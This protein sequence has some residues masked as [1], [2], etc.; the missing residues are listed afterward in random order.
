MNT[1]RV[2]RPR[3]GLPRRQTGAVLVLY[4]VGMLA[5]LL[6][7]G[8]A[9]DGAHAMLNKSRLQNTVDAAA[10]SSAKVLDQTANMAQA[11]TAAL[12]MFA[13]NAND[14]G[15]RELGIAYAG[16]GGDINVTVEFSSTV[17]PFQSGTL[18]ANYVRVTATNFTMPAWLIQLMGID[19]KIVAA[20]A[21]AGPSPSIGQ[22]CDL[23]PLIVCG[24]PASPPDPN[25]PNASI[26]GYERGAVHVL[27]GGSDSGSQSGPI[28]PGNFQLARPGD[29]SGGADLR[30]NLAGGYEDCNDVGDNV[31]TEPG[32]TVGPTVQGI[33]TRL[34]RF[35]GPINPGD[36]PPDV[37][38]EQQGTDLE[39]DDTTGN[40]T[41]DHGSTIVSS[42]DDLDFNFQDYS[43][44]LAAANYD[45]QPSP[46]GPAAFDRRN[47]PVYIADCSGFNAGQTNLPVL[48]FGCFFLLQEAVQKGNEAELYGEFQDVCTAEGTSGPEPTEIPGPYRI[49]LYKDSDSFDS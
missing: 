10:L 40:I 8:L 19:E 29:S 12:A 5:I 33:N 11:Q 37:I 1:R 31:D 35:S 26:W 28:G 39:Y 7:A 23:V 4:T 34:N 20:S 21:V 45:L 48:G 38:V 32:N 17:A 46:L 3:H 9:L 22:S 24:D 49:Q 36:Y 47:M 16:G 6:V 13:D 42:A 25:D 44:R 30:D 43:N 27:K 2:H 15:N 41:L 18:P 14:A